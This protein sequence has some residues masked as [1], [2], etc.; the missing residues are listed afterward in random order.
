MTALEWPSPPG[1]SQWG[2][3][4]AWFACLKLWPACIAAMRYWVFD[5]SLY[6][7]CGSSGFLTKV[8]YVFKFCEWRGELGSCFR[9]W[10]DRAR[11]E[12]VYQEHCFLKTT[13]KHPKHNKKPEIIGSSWEHAYFCVTVVS[14]LSAF[15]LSNRS[16]EEGQLLIT[17][18]Q[19][20]WC[21]LL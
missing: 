1:G 11:P 21:C 16:T 18:S 4:K 8:F 13:K 15:Y 12:F 6:K 5:G 2:S 20:C 3:W 10:R 9:L 14:G 17:T 7:C 19:D